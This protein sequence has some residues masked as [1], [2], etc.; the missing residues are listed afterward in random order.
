MLEPTLIFVAIVH[1]IGEDNE[2]TWSVVSP[3]RAGVEAKVLAGIAETRG[4]PDYYAE[5]AELPEAFNTLD[6]A[7][8]S[9]EFAISV[10]EQWLD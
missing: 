2:A 10:A 4:N 8:N 6:E 9:G 5:D 7:N 3:T 1:P